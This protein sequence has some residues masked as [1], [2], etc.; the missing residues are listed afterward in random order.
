MM[1]MVREQDNV[2]VLYASSAFSDALHKRLTFHVKAVSCVET[3]I[4]KYYLYR[5]NEDSYYMSKKNI[6]TLTYYNNKNFKLERN[7]IRSYV[8]IFFVFFKT[9]HFWSRVNRHIYGR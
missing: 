3:E 8:L 5:D 6:L 1:C 9:F 7:I 2:H 4:L